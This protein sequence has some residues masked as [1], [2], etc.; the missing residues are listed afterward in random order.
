MNIIANKK[1]VYYVPEYN[2]CLCGACFEPIYD[3]WLDYDYVGDGDY[4]YCGIKFE[5][6][7][8]HCHVCVQAAE[9]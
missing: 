7:D 1:N 4:V 8:E 9:D 6:T 2:Q 3:N 5:E